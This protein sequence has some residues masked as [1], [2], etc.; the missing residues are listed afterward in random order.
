MTAPLCLNATFALLGKKFDYPDILRKPT[1]HWLGP[2]GIVIGTVVSSAKFLGPNEE[3]G[4][5]LAGAAVPLLYI[6]WSF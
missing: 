6:A 5:A 2:A 4:W 1:R 3:R